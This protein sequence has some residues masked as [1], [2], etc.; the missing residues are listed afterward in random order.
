M[1]DENWTAVSQS[2]GK[3][4]DDIVAELQLRIR[5]PGWFLIFGVLAGEGC[6]VVYG[7]EID[8]GKLSGR[9]GED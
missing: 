3:I 2:F 6:R 5:H 1:R 7:A 4:L 9:R 8:W